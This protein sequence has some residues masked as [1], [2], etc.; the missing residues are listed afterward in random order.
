MTVFGPKIFITTLNFSKVHIL[1]EILVTRGS[2]HSFNFVW[3][4]SSSMFFY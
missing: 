4:G 3:N 2:R 1:V